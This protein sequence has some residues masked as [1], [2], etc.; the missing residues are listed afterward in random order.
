MKISNL[1]PFLFV[2]FILISCGKK[3]SDYNYLTK[4][5]KNIICISKDPSATVSQKMKA[6]QSQLS[7][8]NEYMTALK[9]LNNDE[10]A[11]FIMNWS[12]ALSEANEGNCD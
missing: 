7:L 9:N 2:C 4:E 10:K 11:K 6:L 12:V 3:A 1:T 8:Q 5:Y